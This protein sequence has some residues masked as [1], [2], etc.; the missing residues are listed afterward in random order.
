MTNNNV[1]TRVQMLMRDNGYDQV[2]LAELANINR[3]TINRYINGKMEWSDKTLRKIASA[4]HSNY[5]WLKTG[6]GEMFE[7]APTK[8]F[9]VEKGLLD[10]KTARAI[11]Q[12]MNS[13][14]TET[15]PR[16]PMAVAAGSLSGLSESIKASDCEQLPVIKAFP[17][18]DC[19]MIVK[20]NSMEPK[21][22]GGDEIALRRVNGFIEWGKTYVLDTRDGAVLKRLYDDGENFRCVSFNPE[23]TDFCVPKTDV[24]GIFKVVGLIRI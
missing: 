1:T 15:R 12:Q 11:V 4:L 21:Y 20:G 3:A 2:A 9:Y 14:E 19:T 24:F 16:I 8:K 6:D 5:H 23:Y 7:E 22:E 17:Q 10:D 18:Y 13:G